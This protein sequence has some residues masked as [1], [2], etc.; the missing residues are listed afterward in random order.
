MLPNAPRVGTMAGDLFDALPEDQPP[1]KNSITLASFRKMKITR[2]I[3]DQS[4]SGLI[5]SSASVGCFRSPSFYLT[6]KLIPR[7][8]LR[9]LVKPTATG[10]LNFKIFLFYAKQE[11]ILPTPIALLACF[12]DILENKQSYKARLDELANLITP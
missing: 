7:R 11:C 3:D 1:E 2:M 10:R 9:K 12:I 6:T 4:S 8:Q 5:F